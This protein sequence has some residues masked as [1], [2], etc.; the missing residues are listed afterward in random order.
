[1]DS[2][3]KRFSVI[4]GFSLLVLVLLGNAWI[5]HQQVEGQVE[6]QRW[7]R[8][9]LQ[10]R[11]AIEQTQ[12]LLTAAETGQR[13]YLY[14]GDPK[15]LQPY[16]NAEARVQQRIEDLRGLVAD[17]PTQLNRVNTVS[18]LATLKLQEMAQTIALYS[19]G[20]ADEARA[21]VLSDRGLLI[22]N[23]LR[24][25]FSQMMKDEDRLEAI[26][27][28]EYEHSIRLTVASIYLVSGFAVV[29]L[30]ALAYYILRERI[31]RERYARE[32]RAREE[33]FRVTLTSIGDA[34]I[35]TDSSGLVTFFNP[36]AESLTGAS[37]TEVIGKPI[38][39]V[40]PI[41]NEFTGHAAENPVSKVMK[42]GII[43]GLA[44]HTALR[45]RDGS[46]IPIEDSAAPIRDINGE[47]IGVVLVFHDVTAERKSQE[48]L[49]KTEKLA[50]AARLSATVAHEIN[51]PLE[52]VTNLIFLAQ[53][54][55]ET[56]ASIREHLA[57]AERELARVAH[58]TRQTLGFYRDSSQPET[59]ELAVIVDSVLSLYANKIEAKH[60]E[61][62]RRL[63]DC[64][65]IWGAAGELKQV[66][67]NLLSN[68]IDAVPSGGRIAVYCSS[69]ET[70]EGPAAELIVE[71]SGPGVS[72]DHVAHIF[73]PFFTTKK[74]VGTGLGLWVTQEII[75]RRGG[76]ITLR[77]DQS[78][79]GLAGA[80]FVVVLP[81]GTTPGSAQ[82]Q[83]PAH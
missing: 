67:S 50:A 73:D 59:I 32:L 13:G 40:F 20:K 36:I 63:D 65:P 9:T 34:V 53:A 2:L 45:H 11:L 72:G 52:A 44:N 33:W 41:F 48:M 76:T 35:A 28:R 30:I 37:N 68:A 3:T 31:L 56:P 58:I 46:L 60:I 57:T 25:Q 8:H 78:A 27:A 55:P 66:V 18:E 10:V 1:M 51:N 74:D 54:S 77:R 62:E 14:T 81:A 26:R 71:D 79:S 69:R 42:L 5:I 21:T 6:S 7:L 70:P 39:D 47:T 61:I 64:P 17:N 19:T 43:V 82:E 49:R 12:E 80:S 4:A 83:N 24:A 15:Y 23:D 16:H 38:G 75:S 22:M 29:G